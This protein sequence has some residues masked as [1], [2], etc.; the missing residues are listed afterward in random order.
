MIFLGH[1]IYT[2]DEAIVD[3]VPHNSL[4][5]V[6]GYLYFTFGNLCLTL[7]P[8]WVHRQSGQGIQRPLEARSARIIIAD[9]WIKYVCLCLFG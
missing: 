1:S 5:Q 2:L 3:K 9:P 8:Y 6:Q 4:Q 7:A